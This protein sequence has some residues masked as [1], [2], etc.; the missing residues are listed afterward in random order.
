[1]QKGD[2]PQFLI[3]IANIGE[4]YGKAVSGPLT[5]IYWETLKS[6]E[7][8][9][10]RRAFSAHVCNPDCGQYFPKPAD[11]VKFIEGGGETKALQA[12]TKVENAIHWVGS[13]ESLAFDDPIIHSV[14]ED[15]GGWVK[16]C[17]LSLEELPFRAL[18]FQK[19]YMGFVIRKP[20]R[21]PR[22]LCGIAEGGGPPRTICPPASP[23][24][25]ETSRL[26]GGRQSAKTTDGNAHNRAC[27]DGRTRLQ[28]VRQSA[29]RRT[30]S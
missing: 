30:D 1:M 11:I 23:L 14:I 21:Y 22:Y 6:F 2:L 15:M 20:S 18:D 13:Y 8:E 16:L 12:W 19:R 29:A 7:L 27:R 24:G 25:I 17:A 4:L 3:L 26:E 9:D 5:D 28:A 10:L